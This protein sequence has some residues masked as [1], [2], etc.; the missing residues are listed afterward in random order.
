MIDQCKDEVGDRSAAEKRPE[1]TSQTD[2]ECFAPFGFEDGRI[3][4]RASQKREHN[5][6]G[7]GEKCDPLGISLQAAGA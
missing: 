1:K 4:F 3:E 6:S 2:D 7:A 5:G